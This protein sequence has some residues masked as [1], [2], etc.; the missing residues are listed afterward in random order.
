MEMLNLF[1]NIKKRQFGRK[2]GGV[3]GP[4]LGEGMN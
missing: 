4:F 1:R 3:K 2:N